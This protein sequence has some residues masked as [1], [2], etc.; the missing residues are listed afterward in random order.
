[1][2][3]KT[4]YPKG[5]DM[6]EAEW[7]LVDAEGQSLGR[8]ATEIASYLL[9]KHKPTF[10]PGVDVGDH[11]VVINGLKLNFTQKRLDNKMYYRHSGYPGGLTE[12]TLA[13]ML[14]KHPERVIE[15]A[16]WGMLPHNK[17]GRHLMKK[18]RVYPGAEHPHEAQ[19]PKPVA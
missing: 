14:D 19:N 10:T 4:Y 7:L 8:L 1:M 12:T 6:P 11:V 13:E 2:V 3:Q 16:V 5:N 18:L 15:Q 9:G 17:F